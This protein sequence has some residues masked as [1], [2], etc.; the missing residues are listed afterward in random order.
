MRY[1]Q[2]ADFLNGQAH[3]CQQDS[4]NLIAEL[5]IIELHRTHV[6]LAL[7]FD[8]QKNDLIEEF[9]HHRTFKESD[10]AGRRVAV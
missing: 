1:I 10:F 6:A 2:I 3:F 8:E 5:G 9:V 7:M 4:I